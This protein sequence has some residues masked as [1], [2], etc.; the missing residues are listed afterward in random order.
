MRTARTNRIPNKREFFELWEAGLLGNRPEL[1][2]DI[3]DVPSGIKRVGFREIGKAGGGAWTLVDRGDAWFTYTEWK[4][5]GRKFIMDGSV[6]NDHS[7]MQGEVCR[8]YRGLESYLCVRDLDWKLFPDWA[9]FHEA[10]SPGGFIDLTWVRGL[11]PMR[12]TM[13]AGNHK[14]RGNLET[15]ELIDHFMDPSSRDDLDALLEQYPDATIE[16]TCFDINTG[17]FPN[18]NTIFWETRNY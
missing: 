6:P 5:L 16:F 2:R 14:S 15:K 8:T 1:W 9:L 18:R 13:S 7:T 4:N 10:R 3:I 17:V 12:Q 11:P